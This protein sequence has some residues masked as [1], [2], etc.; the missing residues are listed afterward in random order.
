[1]IDAGEYDDFFDE[2]KDDDADDDFFDKDGDDDNFFDGQVRSLIWGLF[3]TV[4]N[5]NMERIAQHNAL[6]IVKQFWS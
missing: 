6:M 2:E 4:T 1:M 3:I 5:S